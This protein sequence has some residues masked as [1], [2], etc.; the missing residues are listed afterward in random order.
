MRFTNIVEKVNRSLLAAVEIIFAP[1]ARMERRLVE[2]C[3]VVSERRSG[4]A[5]EDEKLLGILERQ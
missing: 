3:T 1:R 5:A 2:D 4:L